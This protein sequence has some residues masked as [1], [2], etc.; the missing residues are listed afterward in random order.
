MGK[1]WRRR[2]DLVPHS[3]CGLFVKNGTVGTG[4]AE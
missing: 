3:I 2:G 4:N 1:E